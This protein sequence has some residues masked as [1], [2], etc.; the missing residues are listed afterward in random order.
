MRRDAFHDF[1][2]ALPLDNKAKRQSSKSL[3]S[4]CSGLENEH[5]FMA[6]ASVDIPS[7]ILRCTSKP[8]Q[9]WRNDE[10]VQTERKTT[11][12]YLNIV[13]FISYHQGSSCSQAMGN[14]LVK[15]HRDGSSARSYDRILR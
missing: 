8:I 1:C 4:R 15:Y 2:E 5:E 3:Q 12:T 13:D 7:F 10:Y 9:S 14:V 6:T 11:D